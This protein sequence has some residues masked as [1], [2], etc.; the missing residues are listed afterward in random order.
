MGYK[1]NG[2][3]CFLGVAKPHKKLNQE[4]DA[5]TVYKFAKG[6]EWLDQ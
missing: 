5:N 1:K 3:I 6:L 2:Q 4:R